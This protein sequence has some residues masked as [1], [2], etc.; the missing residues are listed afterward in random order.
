MGFRL[1]SIVHRPAHHRRV[2]VEMEKIALGIRRLVA[3]GTNPIG[4]TFVVCHSLFGTVWEFVELV[5]GCFQPHSHSD[6]AVLPQQEVL[7]QSMAALHRN[8][9]GFFGS[10]TIYERA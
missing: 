1:A 8:P 6:V 3:D 2:V 4:A 5:S 10:N 9:G 7:L